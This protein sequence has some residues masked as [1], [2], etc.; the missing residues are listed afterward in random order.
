MGVVRPNAQ[1]FPACGAGSAFEFCTFFT[2]LFATPSVCFGQKSTHTVRTYVCPF[3]GV[4]LRKYV[5]T[6]NTLINYIRWKGVPSF[7]TLVKPFPFRYG[8][9]SLSVSS[10]VTV[11]KASIP[12]HT[13]KANETQTR[14][15]RH[16]VCANCALPDREKIETISILTFYFFRDQGV[17][18]TSPQLW[19]RS[20]D[21]TS[22]IFRS[23]PLDVQVDSLAPICNPNTSNSFKHHY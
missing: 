8:N 2:E 20:C 1:K 16:S 6:P 5:R 15:K 21:A 22:G 4:T 10:T 18:Y 9:A 23:L 13:R 12:S 7:T 11:V 19:R 17:R 14:R 3:Y